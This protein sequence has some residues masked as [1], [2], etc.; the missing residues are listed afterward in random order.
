MMKPHMTVIYMAYFAHSTHLFAEIA[1]ALGKTKDA[2][3][4]S[5]LFEQLKAS[6]CKAYVE[7]NGKIKGDS[8]DGVRVGHRIRSVRRGTAEAGR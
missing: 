6:F 3:T 4:Y 5:T 8:P 7:P 2:G 1:D